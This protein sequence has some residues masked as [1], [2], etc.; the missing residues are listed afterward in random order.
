MVNENEEDFPF[1]EIEAWRVLCQ[2]MPELAKINVFK[3]TKDL[4]QTLR[5]SPESFDLVK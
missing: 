3:L 1:G 4:D 5:K 2:M